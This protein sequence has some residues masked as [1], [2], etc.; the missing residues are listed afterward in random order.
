M[1]RILPTTLFGQLLLGTIVVQVLL[2]GLFIWYTIVSQ[3]AVAEDRTRV[4]IAQQL[5]RLATACAK[6]LSTGD[7]AALSQTLELS[8]IAPTIEIA[9]LTDLG[10][11]TLAV[12]GSGQNRGLDSF[13]LAALKDANR[14]HIYKASIFKARNGQLESM[15]PVLVQGKPAALLWLEP[16]QAVSRSTADIVVRVAMTYGGFAL[17]ANILPIFLIVRTVTRPLRRLRQ[18]TADLIRNPDLN[19]SFPLPVTTTNEAGELTSSF[20]TM[21][22]ELQQQRSGLLE[23]LALLDSLLQNAPIGFAFF[24]PELR[25]VRLNQTLAGM[26][27]SSVARQ[28]G[29]RLS[30]VVPGALADQTENHLLHVFETG[31]GIPNLEMSQETAAPGPQPTWLVHFYPVRTT[32]DSIRWVG[33]IAVQITQRLQA[34]ETLRRTEKLAATGRLAASIAH[35]INNPLEAV[36]NLLYILQNHEPLAPSAMQ[37][38][39]MAQE[40]LQ[41]VSEITQQTLRFYRQPTSP[42]RTNLTEVLESVLKLYL[43]RITAS[44]ITLSRKFR[45]ESEVFGF[46][47]ELRQVFANLIANALDAMP[48]GGELML[49]ILRRTGRRADGIWASGVHVC[50]TDTGI[51]MSADTLRRV[52]EPFFTTKPATGTGLGLWVSEEIV[53]KHCGTMRVRSRTAAPNGTQ[54]EIRSGTSFMIFLP[55]C[56]VNCDPVPQ[57][58]ATSGILVTE[59]LSAMGP[60]LS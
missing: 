25:C 38:V 30:A 16:N 4:R 47:G 18:A 43:S 59:H 17:L 36:T 15:S 40:E 49:S 54:N 23:T 39:L 33:L 3:R 8:R 24:D 60:G 27:E 12:T 45:G 50:V 29:L 13:E 31:Q 57:H 20:N 52:F 22:G 34:E 2:L 21:V 42:A 46:S 9:R 10:G 19:A 58:T 56:G 7:V 55:D 51:G 26:Y 53:R 35:E 48:H 6:P 1:R 5:D 37:F 11:S 41:R 32:Q 28:A 14:Q 44:R